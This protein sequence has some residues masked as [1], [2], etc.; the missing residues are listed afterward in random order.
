[1]RFTTWGMTGTLATEQPAALDYASSRLWH[2]LGAI[3]AACN[4]FRHTSELSRL[5]DRPG[6]TIGVSATLELAVRAALD[7]AAKTNGLCT[8][9]VLS[10]LAAWGYDRDYDEIRGR[11]DW[12][13]P[14]A[15]FVPA[16]EGVE[17]DV[18]AHTIRLEPGCQLDLGASAKSLVVDLVA[19]ELADRGGVVVEV[20]GDVAVR[21]R[22][23]EGPWVI[24]I[25]DTLRLGGDEPRVAIAGGGVAT[26]SLTSRTWRVAGEVVSHIIDPRS[27]AP[28]SGPYATATVAAAN[29]VTANAFATAALL[30]GEE[31]PYFIAQAG[32]SARLVR[33]DGAVVY[34]GGWPTD[35]A[36]S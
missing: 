27:G 9:T 17:L 4:R 28:A 33:H 16:T 11:D 12:T 31:A 6:E 14:P 2:W 5:N 34:V 30:W 19:N 23:P 25:S 1:M 21:G 24:G 22:G 7:A 20:G 3:D 13:A 8:P 36:G 18:D 26:S 15:T 35:G 10:A 29:C 32:W